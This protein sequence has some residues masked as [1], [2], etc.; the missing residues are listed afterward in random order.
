M[1]ADIEAGRA[2]RTPDARH[3][4]GPPDADAL[5]LSQ[6]HLHLD[7]LATGYA[8]QA[9][10]QSMLGP[11]HGEGT[12]LLPAGGQTVIEIARLQASGMVARGRILPVADGLD[13]TLTLSGG[14]VDGQLV[15]RPEHGIQRIDAKVNARNARF[16]GPPAIAARRG[17]FD[18]VILLD[19]AGVKV[20]GT[21]T[22]EG[23]SRGNWTLA[24]LA[25]NLRMSGG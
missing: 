16:E 11:F 13:G 20:D 10:G 9:K 4:A 14:G 19:P 8:W 15:L 7:P 1:A 12:I 2:D 5:G 3:C 17:R 22:G 25:A 18:G 23:L 21:L 24:R 6:V